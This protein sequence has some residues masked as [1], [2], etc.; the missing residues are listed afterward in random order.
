MPH[1][2]RPRVA[3]LEDKLEVKF[4]QHVPSRTVDEP[5]PAA[6]LL[7]NGHRRSTRVSLLV[8]HSW[9]PAPGA[10]L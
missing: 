5:L 6:E 1:Q 3:A 10:L 2:D 8:T 9:L 7:T 4:A